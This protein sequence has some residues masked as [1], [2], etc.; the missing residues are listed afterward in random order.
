VRLALDGISTRELIKRDKLAWKM[1]ASHLDEMPE[2]DVKALLK[3][4]CL[5][6]AIEKI[7]LL[8]EA[9]EQIDTVVR[10]VPQMEKVDIYFCINRLYFERYLCVLASARAKR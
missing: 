8:P 9:I 4:V 3:D 6:L 7:E 1:K 2:Q 10:L 5:K